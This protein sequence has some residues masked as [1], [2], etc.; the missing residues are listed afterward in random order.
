M[1]KLKK[2]VRKIAV[3]ILAVIMLYLAQ[4]LAVF[5]WFKEQPKLEKISNIPRKSDTYQQNPKIE[6]NW[7]GNYL[8]VTTATNIYICG[9]PT[10]A[11]FKKD[12]IE[13]HE[14]YR[15][16]RCWGYA[17]PTLKYTINYNNIF[18]SLKAYLFDNIS[19][20]YITHSYH[21]KNADIIDN[22]I[23]F[24][25]DENY[26]KKIGFISLNK[27]SGKTFGPYK[28][29]KK[30]K[31]NNDVERKK[32]LGVL[33]NTLALYYSD[34]GHYPISNVPVNLSDKNS[35]VYQEL[36]K[37]LR[38]EEYFK[39]PLDPEFHY[40]YISDG[41]SYKLKAR[42]ENLEDKYCKIENGLCIYEISK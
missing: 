39:D 33:G 29:N 34:N 21:N 17:S 30:N 12:R 13:I 31:K 9:Q 1:K 41:K 10:Y 25:D 6:K 36:V 8:D 7:R 16:I 5:I 35:S 42:L 4:Q 37:Y 27:Y 38:D 23:K 18:S 22:N 32:D 19:I 15:Y 28:S 20:S 26:M 40:T 2:L 3:L 11:R 14:F 24:V